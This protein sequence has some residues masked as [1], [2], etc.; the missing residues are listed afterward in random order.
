MIV[1]IS[2]KRFLND[3]NCTAIAPPHESDRIGVS[4]SIKSLFYSS[5]LS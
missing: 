5:F 2:D 3:K 1:V 4:T